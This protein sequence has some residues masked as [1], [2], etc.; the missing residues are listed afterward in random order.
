MSGAGNMALDEALMHRA[1][2][3]GEGVVRVYTWNQATLSVGRNQRAIG[4]YDPVRAAALGVA[5]VRRPTGG[6]AVLHHREITYSVTAPLH[7]PAGS[8]PAMPRA[9]LRDA[10]ESINAILV[11]SL[12]ALGAEV[13][14]ARATARTPPPGSA[15]CFELPTDGELTLGAAKLAGSSQYRDGNTYLQHGSILVRD[16]QGL[17]AL[18]ATGIPTEVPPAATLADALGRDVPVEEFA[19]SLFDAVR[20]RWDAEALELSAAEVAALPQDDLRARYASEEW[21]W[22]R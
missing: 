4:A 20:Q 1:R 3:T 17:L 13:S 16:D 19:A 18:I 6:R 14:I 2:E 10:Y 22:R 21:T 11:E 9:R 5:I 7:S 8:A 15:P 12:R